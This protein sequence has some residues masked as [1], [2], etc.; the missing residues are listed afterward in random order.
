VA[1][2]AFEFEFLE[3]EHAS[4]HCIYIKDIDSNEDKKQDWENVVESFTKDWNDVSLTHNFRKGCIFISN[5][6]QEIVA[7][8]S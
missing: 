4:D 2:G 5:N 6:L 1:E 7:K 3:A 8:W